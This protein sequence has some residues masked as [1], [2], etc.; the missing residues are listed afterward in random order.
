MT[1]YVVHVLNLILLL[2]PFSPPPLSLSLSPSLSEMSRVVKETKEA[3]KGT[4]KA[5]KTL[6]NKRKKDKIIG[7]LQQQ[8]E[9][10]QIVS[11][12]T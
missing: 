10:M 5:G 2:N 9:Q 1:I 6:E 11:M 8:F 4:I 7:P 3:V 12:S